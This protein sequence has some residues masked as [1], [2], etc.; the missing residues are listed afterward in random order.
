MK[1]WLKFQRGKSTSTRNWVQ[2]ELQEFSSNRSSSAIKLSQ[3][4]LVLKIS[5]SCATLRMFRGFRNGSVIL[6]SRPGNKMVSHTLLPPYKIYSWASWEIFMVTPN[7]LSKKDWHFRELRG[8]MEWT[9]SDLR[10]QGVGAEVKHTPIIT[11]E[12]EDQVWKSKEMGTDTPKH[13]L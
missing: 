3:M 13:L 4:M 1:Q 9:F 5:W 7:F 8:T 11:K 10:K 12:E 2:L 6:L